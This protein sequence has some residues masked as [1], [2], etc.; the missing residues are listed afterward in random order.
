MEP[1]DLA[2]DPLEQIGA[3]TEEARRAGDTMPEAMCLATASA[4]GA[5]SARMVLLRG[6]DHGLVFFT[7]YGSAKAADLQEN[8]RAAAV[9]HYFGPAHRQVRASGPVERTS[10]EES[11]RYWATRHPQ[12]RRSAVVSHQSSVID[13]RDEL[14]RAVA[15][16]AG[17]PDPARPD[18]W[19]GYRL[20]PYEV[21]LWE[22]G[23]HRLHDR[24]RFVRAAGGWRTARLSP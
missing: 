11:D 6:L 24:I 10:A 16:L 13:S 20:V 5:P 12:S 7:D 9:L 21:E 23:V 19:G 4:D 3:W 14:E 1:G 8:P 18:R 2:G 17:D 15:A 22:E